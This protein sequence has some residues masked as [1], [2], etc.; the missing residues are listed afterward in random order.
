M[1]DF[2]LF[3]NLQN[4]EKIQQHLSG[5]TLQQRYKLLKTR[6]NRGNTALHKA[7]LHNHYETIRCLLDSLTYPATRMDILFAPN[8]HG[9]L[10]IHWACLKDNTRT[11][12]CILNFV[13]PRKRYDLVRFQNLGGQNVAY[14]AIANNSTST[15]RCLLDALDPGS[16]Y[17]ILKAKDVK[18][19]TAIHMA[20]LNGFVSCIRCSL[21]SLNKEDRYALLEIADDKSNATA[22]HYASEKN[23]YEIIAAVVA[24][25]STDQWQCLALLQDKSGFT[26]FH[27]LM[28][29]EQPELISKLLEPFNSN[30]TLVT[31][32]IQNTFGNTPLHEAAKEDCAANIESVLHCAGP[33]NVDLLV[34]QNESGCTPIHIAAERGY[35]SSLVNLVKVME[36]TQL[37]EHLNLKQT[38]GFTPL[39]LAVKHAHEEVIYNLI[40]LI[41][42]STNCYSML[43]AQD[44]A[45]H[46]VLHWGVKCCPV[47]I[48]KRLSEIVTVDEWFSLLF[49]PSFANMYSPIHLTADSAMLDCVVNGLSSS[50]RLKLLNLKCSDDETIFMKASKNGQTEL[51]EHI[52]EVKNVAIKDQN[53]ELNKYSLTKYYSF[54]QIW[55]NTV[56]YPQNHS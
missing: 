18:G 27:L 15:L 12:T 6:D 5:L 16:I 28:K 41:S 14:T 36:P 37:E 34:A 38:E 56:S 51:A 26:L 32:K 19:Y 39:T 17:K 42:Q 10:A 20:A 50:Q 9:S 47:S 35:I 46:T 45:G 25:V 52:T 23:H 1:N 3:R 48:V 7:A 43:S 33:L 13:S 30:Q 2:S 4:Y 40:G 8:D 11:I 21:E 22:L 24:L 53:S 54:R 55:Y 49:T 31:M 29:R 44:I